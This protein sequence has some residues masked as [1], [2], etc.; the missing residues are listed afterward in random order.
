M[1][2]LSR[3]PRV[4]V[5]VC[6]C[7]CQCQCQCL[8][9]C[10]CLPQKQRVETVYLCLTPQTL[11]AL[12]A[13]GCGEYFIMVRPSEPIDARS[14]SWMCATHTPV[15]VA[16]WCV[17]VYVLVCVCVCH[18]DGSFIT[19]GGRHQATQ[20]L[21]SPRHPSTNLNDPS[22]PLHP[23]FLRLQLFGRQHRGLWGAQLH[24]LPSSE[25]KGGRAGQYGLPLGRSGM[26]CAP[27]AALA[28]CVHTY[29]HVTGPKQSFA[30]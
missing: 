28:C 21:I 4:C 15:N 5:C 20:S 24:S 9:Q 16:E 11:W 22:P 25:G 3:L 13:A 17:C 6:L 8:C 1:P 10:L 14:C 7:V 27:C 2:C 26:G 12:W 29:A 30:G 18:P 23:R 19:L